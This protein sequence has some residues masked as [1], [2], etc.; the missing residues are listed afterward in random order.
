MGPGQR[1]GSDI[2]G[3][4]LGIKFPLKIPN[5]S[6]FSLRVKKI[7]SGW[8]NKYPRQSWVGLLFHAGQKYALVGSGPIKFLLDQTSLLDFYANQI[9]T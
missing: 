5:F 4:G 3:L 9:S 6:I 1:V 2:F 8:V 7:S